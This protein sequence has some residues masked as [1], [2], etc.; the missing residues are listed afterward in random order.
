MGLRPSVLQSSCERER[1]RESDTVR[2][3]QLALGLSG[4]RAL[5][6]SRA[7]PELILILLYYMVGKGLLTWHDAEQEK[8]DI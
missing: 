8:K 1:E 5:G 4:S 3:K 6:S 2:V 7:S